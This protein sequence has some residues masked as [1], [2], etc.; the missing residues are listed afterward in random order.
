MK[1]II[2]ALLCLTFTGLIKAQ[3]YYHALG[4]QANIG[5]FAA[6]VNPLDDLEKEPVIVPGLFYKATLAFEINR[7]MNFAVSAYPFIGMSGS[8]NSQSGASEGTSI[9]AEFP[10]LAELYFG[11]IEQNCFFVG[12]GFSASVMAS[13][14]GSGST[15]GPQFDLGGQFEIKEKIIGLRAAFT[16]GLNTPGFAST[17]TKYKNNQVS[18]G[19]YYLFG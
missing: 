12:V 16:L 3:D 4:I 10:L 9:G 13:T 7:D 1:K 5:L 17:Y 8:I 19:L 6:Q 15:V 11:D 18:V 14:Y 2:L